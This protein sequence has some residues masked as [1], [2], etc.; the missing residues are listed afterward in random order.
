MV[1]SAG[2]D[3]DLSAQAAA[4]EGEVLRAESRAEGDQDAPA[5]PSTG[6]LLAALL[7][8][9]FDI[10]A[11]DWRVTDSECEML[12]QAYGAVIDKYFPDLEMG[13]ELTAVLVTAAVLGPRL[14]KPRRQEKDIADHAETQTTG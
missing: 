2:A 8:P 3:A 9:T 11:P 5:G 14:R 7:R 4:L 10:V 13:V 1:V 6:E 12:G